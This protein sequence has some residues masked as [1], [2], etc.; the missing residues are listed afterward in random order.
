VL[1]YANGLYP[2]Y[3]Q[4]AFSGEVLPDTGRYGSQ[5]ASTVPLV[6]SVPGGPDVSI[7]SVQTTIGPSH[8][9]YYKHVHSRLVA[10]RPRGVSVPERCP[11]GGFPFAADFTFQDGSRASAQTTAPCPPHHR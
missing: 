1:F 11:R 4:L 10:F 7:V 2:V 5:L 9:T 8:L 3:A 6:T